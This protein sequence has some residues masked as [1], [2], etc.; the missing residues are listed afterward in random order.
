MDQFWSLKV[1]NINYKEAKFVREA[2]CLEKRHIAVD[3]CCG[4]HH[5]MY[6]S[7][8]AL[9]GPRCREYS[10]WMECHSIAPVPCFALL[11]LS[12]LEHI[13]PHLVSPDLPPPPP[14][15]PFSSTFSFI[16]SFSFPFFR[17]TLPTIPYQSS[18][19]MYP[20]FIILF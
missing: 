11:F 18:H 9:M 20:F 12:S 1:I 14:S 2:F 3:N 10:H 15:S 6:G 17:F 4:G 7:S 5:M 19:S 13:S 8:H 16:L